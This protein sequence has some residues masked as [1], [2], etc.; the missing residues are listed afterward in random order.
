M[1]TAPA[2][3]QV[4]FPRL[5]RSETKD[6]K[7]LGNYCTVTSTST[8]R[9]GDRSTGIAYVTEG[10]IRIHLHP[11]LSTLV[12]TNR[13]TS[14]HFTHFVSSFI[15]SGAHSAA[16]TAGCLQTCG[17]IQAFLKKLLP[18]HHA[19]FLR[20]ICDYCFEKAIIIVYH[21]YF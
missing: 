6:S 21:F 12:R 9:H 7:V 11:D 19:S 17:C 15:Q 20:M 3:L 18:Y 1:R 8:G 2:L 4:S 5:L 14:I 10:P 13:D 16:C